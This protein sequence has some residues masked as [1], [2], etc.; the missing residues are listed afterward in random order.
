MDDGEDETT[1]SKVPRDLSVTLDG[2]II[3]CKSTVAVLGVTIDEAL[4]FTTHME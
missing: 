1:L 2:V 4:S 3:L